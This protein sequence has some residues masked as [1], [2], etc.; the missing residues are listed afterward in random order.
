MRLAALFWAA[1]Q[2]SMGS[3]AFEKLREAGD[4]VEALH[5]CVEGGDCTPKAESVG[6][7]AVVMKGAHALRKAW[8]L[9]QA[10]VAASGPDMD[11]LARV[12]EGCGRVFHAVTQVR[13]EKCLAA[14]R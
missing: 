12:L 13:C 5:Q 1:S 11:T 8:Q 10:Q 7:A 3:A 14:R 9:P 2:L 4:A 6:L